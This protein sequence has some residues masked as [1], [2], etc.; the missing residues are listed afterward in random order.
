MRPIRIAPVAALLALTLSAGA[1]GSK[2]A[3]GPSISLSLE[4]VYA[5]AGELGSVMNTYNA[6]SVRAGL[7]ALR[8]AAPA[9]GV[10][11]VTPFNATANCPGG[12]TT[13]VT[14]SYEGTTTVTADATFSYS[15]CKTAHYTTSGSFRA[16]AT[17]TS[18]ATTAT[19]QG[20]VGGTLTVVTL[21]GRSG[22]CVVDLTVTMTMGQTGN[23]VTAVSG[24][25]CGAK[26]SGTY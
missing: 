21:D 6:A 26:V 22:A 4:E 5:L 10:A 18:T 13:S 12:G 17:A 11:A 8:S 1:C 16:N 20:T 19:A 23:P 15:D 2:D 7:G 3:T 24:T 25:A 14:G 9:R